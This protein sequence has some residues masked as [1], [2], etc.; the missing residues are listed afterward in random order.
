MLPA[1]SM[2]RISKKPWE[3]RPKKYSQGLQ[4]YLVKMESRTKLF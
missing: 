4:M 1:R 2:A 3:R